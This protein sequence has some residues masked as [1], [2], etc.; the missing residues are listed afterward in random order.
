M[1]RTKCWVDQISVMF[2]FY[3]PQFL[4]S[5]IKPVLLF[6]TFSLHLLFILT[7]KFCIS[8]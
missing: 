2:L 4:P 1:E 8:S 6:I 5:V 3:S 7:L